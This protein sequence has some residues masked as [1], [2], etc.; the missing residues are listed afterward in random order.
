[1]RANKSTSDDNQGTLIDMPRQV[2][3]DFPVATSSLA[4]TTD[5]YTSQESAAE[6]R[7]TEKLGR[8]QRL[9][10]NTVRAYPGYTANHL[11]RA[12]NMPAP[13]RINRRLSELE[14]ADLIRSDG[15]EVDPVTGR[16]CLKWWSVD[17]QGEGEL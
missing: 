7:D 5:P 8:A 14:R 11:A 17:R 6:M 16:R 4:R 13:R 2:D 1:M 10:L 3:P 15:D 12:M 9:T